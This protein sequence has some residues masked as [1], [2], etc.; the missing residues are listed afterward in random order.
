M[1]GWPILCH[2]SVQKIIAPER[3]G[4]PYFPSIRPLVTWFYYWECVM[5]WVLFLR[6]SKRPCKRCISSLFD[7]FF[8]FRIASI[9]CRCALWLWAMFCNWKKPDHRHEEAIDLSSTKVSADFVIKKSIN[10]N[11]PVA[12]KSTFLHSIAINSASKEEHHIQSREKDS[13][14][15]VAPDLC[16]CCSR[17]P[18]ATTAVYYRRGLFS[19]T[20][21]KRILRLLSETSESPLP[22]RIQSELWTINPTG[23][24]SSEENHCQAEVHEEKRIVQGVVESAQ[25]FDEEM[26]FRTHSTRIS[27][28]RSTLDDRLEWKQ[29]VHDHR[30]GLADH[31]LRRWAAQSSSVGKVQNSPSIVTLAQSV[32]HGDLLEFYPGQC[33]PV[34]HGRER[35]RQP[36]G[37]KELKLR[38]P[39]KWTDLFTRSC[40]RKCV[41]PCVLD[42]FNMKRSHSDC[43]S[44]SIGIESLRQVRMLPEIL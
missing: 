26:A 23:R 44:S 9:R 6:R 29:C 12:R 31:V 8:L 24:L 28:A 43:S 41:H 15:Y 4:L 19:W 10:Q 36:V 39:K 7:V 20:E 37:R 17:V 30:T 27:S 11:K 32:R 34:E 14:A 16:L 22:N 40:S 33:L 25:S 5:E 1:P 3:Y 2:W 35:S 21:S 13:D 42:D 18:S 38:S